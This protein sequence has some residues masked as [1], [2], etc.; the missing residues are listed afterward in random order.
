MTTT[1]I[2]AGVLITAAIT[3]AL[4]IRKL[5][6]ICQPNEALVISGTRRRRGNRVLGYRVIAGGRTLRIPLIEKVDRLDLSNLTI[7]IHLRGAYSRGGIPLNVEGVANVK[8]ASDETVMANA[9]ERF[10]GQPRSVIVGVAKEVLEGNLRGVLAT[11]TP[12]EVNNDRVKFAAHLLQEAEGDLKRIGLSLDTLKIQNVGD[13]RGYLDSI[14]RKQSADVVMSSRI[15]EA[16]NLAISKEREATNYE[17]KEMA[18][19]DAW[20][21]TQRADIERRCV[22]ADARE[23]ALVA[24]A[25]STVEANLAKATAELEVQKARVDQVKLRLM[26]DRVRPA[27]AARD[28]RLAE[29]RAEVAPIVRNGEATAHALLEMGSAW[30]AAGPDASRVFVAQHLEQLIGSLVDRVA[31]RPVTKLTLVDPAL[32]TG[33]STLATQAKVAGELIEHTMDMDLSAL[34]SAFGTKQPAS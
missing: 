9:I 23:K 3:G 7:D 14:G 5:I 29:A 15:A 26:A 32:A 18:K 4:I 10:L 21:Q 16:D 27:E 31:D 19:M 6:L 8:I 28:R 11:L 34:G 17:E 20:L 1:L 33:G 22:E 30:K 13:D 25:Q 12:E 2:I 24:E